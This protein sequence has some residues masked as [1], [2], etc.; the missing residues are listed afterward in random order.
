MLSWLQDRD[1]IGQVDRLHTMREHARNRP[2]SVTGVDID[3]AYRI[4]QQADMKAQRDG[5]QN[6]IQHAIVGGKTA[7]EHAFHTSLAQFFCKVGILKTGI[8]ILILR[9]GF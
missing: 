6:R 1:N 9:H 3:C 4:Q 7:D 8:S 5:L 2:L